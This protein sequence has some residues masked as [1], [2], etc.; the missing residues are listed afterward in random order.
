MCDATENNSFG[1]GLTD[2]TLV[3]CILKGHNHGH[4]VLDRYWFSGDCLTQ[5]NP[6]CTSII[7]S[8][9]ITWIHSDDI[10][11]KNWDFSERRTPV[12]WFKYHNEFIIA[13]SLYPYFIFNA[14]FVTCS[15]SFLYSLVLTV[16]AL[17]PCILTIY[18]VLTEH[19]IK[20]NH[21]QPSILYQ[22]S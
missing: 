16:G 8:N 17:T 9:Q 20:H 4:T 18:Y 15:H 7:S 6:F 1:S 11:I 19:A 12:G 21:N 14:V 22:L 13:T 2:V 3:T 10:I 5:S